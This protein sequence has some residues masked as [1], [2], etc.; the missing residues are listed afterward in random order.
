MADG[1]SDDC[2]GVAR[3]QQSERTKQTKH[4]TVGHYMRFF[5]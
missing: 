2:G 4:G 3:M 1:R 5:Q